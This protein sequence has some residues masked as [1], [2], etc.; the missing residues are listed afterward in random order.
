[1]KLFKTLT[2]VGLMTLVLASC[3]EKMDYNEY[4]AYDQEYIQRSFSYVGGFMAK[5]YNDIDSD[6]G[7]NSGAMLASATDESV[8]SHDGNTIED[9]YNG[10]WSASNPHQTIWSSAYEGITYCNE[11]LDNWTNLQF[12]Q[13]ALN[14]DYEQQMF[15]Y[16]N[17]QYEARWAR[18]YFYYTLVRQYGGVPFKIHNT[19]GEEETALP[20]TSAD[21]IFQFIIS[22]CDD[23]KD[24]IIADYTNIG[25][26]A[27]YKPQ[28]GRASKFAVEALKAQA[29]LY[30]ASPLFTQGKSEAEKAALWRAAAEA[31]R[32]LILDAEAG[33]KG[34]AVSLDTLWNISYISDPQCYKEIL[35]ARRTAAANTFESYNFP[36]G[37]SSGQGGN[38]PTQDFVD[39]FD[40]TDGL[41]I[42]ES[43]LYDPQNPYANRD[44][45]LE[46]T[47]AH[48]GDLWPA[49]TS[50]SSAILRRFSAPVQ[51]MLFLPLLMVGLPSVWAACTSTMLRLCSSTSRPS[52]AP[53]LPMPLARDSTIRHA[54][55][56]ALPASA[57][58]CLSSQRV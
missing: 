12:E 55:W 56:P 22:E 33:G 6:W 25:D 29:A 15:L 34:L 45:R 48:N 50:R 39:A 58:V 43:P 46:M 4:T 54:I 40:C 27:L 57:L 51:V 11:V 10:N 19:T 42:T 3:E 36:V 37:Y 9:F 31:N 41:P 52:V 7:N 26:M 44:P 13:F 38:C 49:I 21:E 47:V 14:K 16:N 23:I 1:M 17:Y 53:M 20:R 24:K 18:A 32:E 30:Q 8:Y 2:G 5:I 35:F 28:T